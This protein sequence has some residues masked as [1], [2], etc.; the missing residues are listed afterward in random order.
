MD[1]LIRYVYD[2][3]L[4]YILHFL[5]LRR[6][7]PAL[8]AVCYAV[9]GKAAV[10]RKVSEVSAVA[11]KG[12]AVAVGKCHGLIDIIPDKTSLIQFLFTYI[13]RVFFNGTVGITHCVSIFAA[14]IRFV[15]VI[16][17]EFFDLIHR[18][19][20]GTCYVGSC[21]ISG[22]PVYSFIMN[23]SCV[24]PFMKSFMHFKYVFAAVCFVSERPYEYAGMV[25]VTHEHTLCPVKHHVLILRTITRNSIILII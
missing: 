24:I 7:E 4:I 21:R 5:H 2:E 19:I 18:K 22:I 9:S 14:Y 20:H 10:I 25:L 6:G 15:A 13:I 3:I 23:R 17:E 16:P 12:S 11:F 8:S 1:V